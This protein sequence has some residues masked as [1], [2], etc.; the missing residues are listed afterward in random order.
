MTEHTHIEP[1]LDA[2]QRLYEELF[3][4]V[5]EWHQPTPTPTA[6]ETDEDEALYRR[7]FG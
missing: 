7:L 6:D 4:V 2:D 5:P 3:G 1:E